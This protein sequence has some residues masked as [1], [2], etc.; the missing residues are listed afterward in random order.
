MRGE[1]RFSAHGGVADP[2][3]ANKS[4]RLK[5]CHPACPGVPWNRSVAKWRD[6]LFLSIHLT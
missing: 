6:L 5:L 2:T 4:R 3:A 1:E